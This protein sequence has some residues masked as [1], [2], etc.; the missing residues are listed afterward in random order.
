MQTTECSID[1]T[2]CVFNSKKTRRLSSA[3]RMPDS[4]SNSNPGLGDVSDDVYVTLAANIVQAVEDKI[5]AD[6]NNTQLTQC[7][8]KSP[9]NVADCSFSTLSTVSSLAIFDTCT[10]AAFEPFVR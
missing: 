2:Q 9:S 1:T 7:L 5:N 8:E 3:F 6:V 4:T 10:D